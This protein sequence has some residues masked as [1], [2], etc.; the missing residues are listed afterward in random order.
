MSLTELEKWELRLSAVLNRVDMKLEEEYGAEF[1][2][3]A[4]RPP[5]GATS[6]PKYDGLFSLGS[7]FSLGYASGDG[8]NYVISLRVS[9]FSAI[10]VD[11]WEAMLNF[12]AEQLQIELDEEFL[13]QK[14][15][16]SIDGDILRVSGDLNFNN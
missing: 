8:P 1:P 3:R 5:P 10:P 4:N 12:T 16:V 11:K 15:N 9:T 14:L 2:R 13:P 7:A 6:N